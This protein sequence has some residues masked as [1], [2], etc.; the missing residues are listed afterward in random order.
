MAF[1]KGELH[2]KLQALQKVIAVSQSYAE[3]GV[4]VTL[5]VES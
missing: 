2:K 5:R 1:C 3:V 4:V